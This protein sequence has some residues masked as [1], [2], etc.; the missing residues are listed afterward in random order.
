MSGESRLSSRLRS[1][2]ESSTNADKERAARFAALSGMRHRTRGKCRVGARNAS[3][4]D[5]RGDG[6]H[7]EGSAFTLI[8]IA[9]V[10]VIIATLSTIAVPVYISVMQGAKADSAQEEMRQVQ[11]AITQHL[12]TKGE[13][14]E[15]L[16]EV[17]MAD[18]LDPWGR[19]YQ[20]LRIAT[21]PGGKKNNEKG[22]FRK[23]HF[24]VPIN[25]DYDLYSMGPDGK[26]SSPLTAKSSR[27]DIIR[28][29]DGA[30]FGPAS[31]Y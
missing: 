23:D 6:S 9:I 17:G 21:P 30:Y 15:S 2:G 22:K 1:A 27:D 14:P 12:A 18:V 4:R 7:A 13:L 16:E 10:V 25:S 24:L 31:E 3:A 28:A 19:P 26:S 29:N 8:E 5:G 11:T 20:Y